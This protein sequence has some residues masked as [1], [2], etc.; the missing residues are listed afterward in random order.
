MKVKSF[1]DKFSAEIDGYIQGIETVNKSKSQEYNELLDIGKSLADTDFSSEINEEQIFNR[2]VKNVENRGDKIMKK[3]NKRRRPAVIA[4]SVAVACLI[5]GA[6]IQPSFAKDLAEKVLKTFNVGNYTVVQ[7]DDKSEPSEIKV[8]DELKGKVFDKNGKVIE[9]FTKENSKEL[10]TSK[11][12]KIGY[13]DASNGYKIFTEAGYAEY[14]KANK[15]EGV[16]EVKDM[17]EVNKKLCFKVMLPSYLPEGFKFEKAELYGDKDNVSDKC[18][19]LTFEN[20]KTGKRFYMQQRWVCEETQCTGGGEKVEEI[21]INGVKALVT[22]DSE[23][24][25]EY[26]NIMNFLMKSRSD[27]SKTELIKIAESMK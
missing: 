13:I 8:P 24:N 25:W 1:E 12:E 22:D 18:V 15:H 19:G 9:V 5:S 20:E 6:A 16:I 2:I 26:N 11:G 10:Y 3:C 7:G 14:E 17:N 23:I 27:L 4:A 21:K